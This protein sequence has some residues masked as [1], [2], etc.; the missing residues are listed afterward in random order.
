M[1]IEKVE[2]ITNIQTTLQ[3]GKFSP[4]EAVLARSVLSGYY[5]FYSEQLEDIKMRKPN[6]WL[7]MRKDHKSDKATDRA[8]ELTEDGLNEMGLEMRLK[9]LQV[10][11]SSLKSIIDTG[12]VQYQHADH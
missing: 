9:R 7:F 8:Y 6:A 4:P 10:M 2:S 1:K 5:A 12:N 3:G 11:M